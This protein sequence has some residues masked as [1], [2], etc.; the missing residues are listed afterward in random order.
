[1]AKRIN[2]IR[3]LLKED[4][5]KDK[6]F[7]LDAELDKLAKEEDEK[8][9][10]KEEK[11]ELEETDA[12]VAKDEGDAEEKKEKDLEECDLEKK[13]QDSEKKEE[14]KEEEKDE[15]EEV[16]A[17][18]EEVPAEEDPLT[19]EL[20]VNDSADVFMDDDEEKEAM[21]AEVKDEVKEEEKAEEKAEEKDE[22]KEEEKAEEKEEDEEEEKAEVKEEEKAEEKEEDEEEKLE[23]DVAEH[24]T[25][26][27]NGEQLTEEFKNKAKVIFETAVKTHVLGLAKQLKTRY[28]ARLNRAKSLIEEKLVNQVDGYLEHITETFINENKLAI[29][30]GL[31]TEITEEFITDLRTLFESHNIMIPKGKENLTEELANKVED[32]K[33]QLDGETKKNL[34]MRKQIN[35]MK[36]T[37]I[38]EEV[39]EGLTD[40]ESEKMKSLASNLDYTDEET[41]KKKLGTLKES[42]FVQKQVQS[43]TEQIVE[44]KNEENAAVVESNDPSMQQYLGVLRKLR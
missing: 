23:L 34:L 28:N 29:E 13:D 33:K 12:E 10:D 19:L 40:T 22:V 25:A 14:V 24:V 11:K 26:L 5:L 6:E 41:Y 27:F 3:Q 44:V 37:E 36:K 43:S 30:S 9:E 2:K 15:E 35:E 16:L 7:D 42:Y 18:E 17:P 21:E 32:L 1:M 38:L 39:C 4:E 31:K 8:A 20:D